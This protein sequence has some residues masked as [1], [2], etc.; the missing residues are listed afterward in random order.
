MIELFERHAH[1]ALAAETGPRRY[2]TGAYH[3]WRLHMSALLAEAGLA[4]HPALIDALL[5]PLAP[6][7][8]AHQRASGHS[9]DEIAGDLA[10][11]AHRVLGVEFRRARSTPE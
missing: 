1:L 2:G 4:D 10:T 9:A 3:A 8:Y 6:E 11:L 7:L 5:A